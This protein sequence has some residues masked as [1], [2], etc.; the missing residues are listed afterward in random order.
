MAFEVITFI[1]ND[2]QLDELVD[3][4]GHAIDTSL[5]EIK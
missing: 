4:L 3:K 1:I 2:E 5:G